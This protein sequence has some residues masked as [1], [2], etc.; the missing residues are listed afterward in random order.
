[1]WTCLHRRNP[2]HMVCRFLH[3]SKRLVKV[4]RQIGD[5]YNATDVPIFTFWS[6]QDKRH[7]RCRRST[8]HCRVEL[9]GI[10]IEAL[11][12]TRGVLS[13]GQ[14]S[15]G[16]TVMQRLKPA[17]TRRNFRARFATVIAGIHKNFNRNNYEESQFTEAS[18]F[19]YLGLTI[20]QLAA[21]SRLVRKGD[22]L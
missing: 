6:D 8:I 18:K 9:R 19:M 4:I 17:V 1:M 3:N 5:L 7:S 21:Y 15:L 11:Q 13:L 12:S 20:E 10:R 14:L 22:G 2:V 16:L